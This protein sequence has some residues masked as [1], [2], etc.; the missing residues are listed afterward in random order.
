MN[1]KDRNIFKCDK[2]ENSYPTCNSLRRHIT[3]KHGNG[4]KNRRI[5]QSQKPISCSRCTYR[6]NTEKALLV[7]MDKHT[8]LEYSCIEPYCNYYHKNLIRFQ[9]HQEKNNHEKVTV[10]RVE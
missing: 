1:V 8:D 2:C 6:T 3:I 7:H 4:G 9:N 10:A 5:D